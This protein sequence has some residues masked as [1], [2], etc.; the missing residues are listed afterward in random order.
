MPDFP[1]SHISSRGLALA[2]AAESMLRCMGGGEAIFR[3]PV[4]VQTDN[5]TQQELGMEASITDDVAVSPVILRKN[6][7]A[8]ELLVSP[9]SLSAQLLHRAQRAEQLFDAAASVQAQ[10]RTLRIQSYSADVF[11]ERVYLYRIVA[12]E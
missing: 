8:F 12:V 9:K 4:S 10:G 6:K 11:A 2:Q 1:V 7:D 5:P 3:L